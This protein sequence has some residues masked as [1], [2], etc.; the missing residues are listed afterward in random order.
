MRKCLW[1]WALWACEQDKLPESPDKSQGKPA[2]RAPAAAPIL[3][4]AAPPVDAAPA[5]PAELLA[6][7][8]RITRRIATG[9][10]V[11]RH[12]AE[13]Y[14]LQIAGA[15]ALLVV[16]GERGVPEK[17]DLLGVRITR[18]DPVTTRQLLGT[19]TVTGATTTLVFGD[20]KL[21]CTAGKHAVARAGAVRAPSP[22]AK[23]SECGDTGRFI[24]ATTTK[25]DAFRCKTPDDVDPSFVFAAAPGIEW[26]FVND[27]CAMQGGGWRQIASDGSIA[28][29]RDT[30][31][32][33]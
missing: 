15:Q 4:D 16:K 8:P 14:T 6:A 29:F 1:L 20:I 33:R 12:E 13:T 31:D 7:P 21:T 3:I 32:A 18:W 5:I 26:I 24:P 28:P 22:P 9:M 11:S 25:V 17:G 30:K 27:D 2:P 19:A 10:A 23:N